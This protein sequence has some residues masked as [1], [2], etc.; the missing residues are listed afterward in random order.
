MTILGHG[1]GVVLDLADSS[2]AFKSVL[3]PISFAKQLSL[4]NNSGLL[5]KKIKNLRLLTNR[6][7]RWKLNSAYTFFSETF[8][9]LS[10][11][12]KLMNCRN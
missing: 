9:P 12:K 2:A 7:Q 8:D 11:L 3:R 4:I 10:N 1:V 6:F 5:E